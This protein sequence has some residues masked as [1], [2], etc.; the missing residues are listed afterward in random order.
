MEEEVRTTEEEMN[1]KAT[2]ADVEAF[3]KKIGV[4]KSGCTY[5]KFTISLI[6][7]INVLYNHTLASDSVN[8]ECLKI[9]VGEPMYVM[10]ELLKVKEAHDKETNARKESF[11]RR[12]NELKRV[13]RQNVDLRREI[14]KVHT[15]NVLDTV[16][17]QSIKNDIDAC[18]M[19]DNP[20]FWFMEQLKDGALASARR[21]E[22][23]MAKHDS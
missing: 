6:T 20:D 23:L 10:D 12:S 17:L 5:N 8:L 16:I 18:V 9:L 2:L 15:D 11:E 3:G 19:H 4:F 1:R 7:M 22:N 21:L 13:E 14:R